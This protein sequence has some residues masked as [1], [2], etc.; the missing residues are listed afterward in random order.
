MTCDT[1]TRLFNKNFFLLWQGQ[2]VSQMGNQAFSIAMMFWIKH[3]TG[4]ATLMGLIMMFSSLPSVLLGPIAGTFADRWS[5]RSIIIW[6]DVFRGVA[7]LLLAGLLFVRGDATDLII[8]CLFIVAVITASMSAFFRPAITAAIPDLVPPDRVASANSMNQS[9]MQASMLAGQSVGGVLFRLL[10]AP[11]LF[12]IDGVSYIVSAISEMFITIPQ[13]KIAETDGAVTALQRFK[14]ETLEG[15]R[16]VWRNR[17]LRD[18]T[19]AA[20]FLNFFLIPIIVLLPF[21]VEDT[22]SSTTDWYGFLL[23]GFGLGALI[24]F[25]GAGLLRPSPRARCWTMISSLVLMS[26]A[27]G[28]LGLVAST[29]SA[30]ILMFLAGTLN[31][32]VNVNIM[33]TMQLMTPS[34][35]R[36]R[37]FGL[38]GTVSGGLAPLAMGLTGVVA[39]L[40]N[41][42]IPLIYVICGGTTA[43]L[44]VLVSFGR[45][46]RS[47]LSY[48]TK[49]EP[50]ENPRP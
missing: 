27:L 4:S 22:L 33:T 7:V 2:F 42:N 13:K 18:L 11:V 3:E 15:L 24:G 36:G 21:Y 50:N 19:L 29:R 16:F 47:F 35:I 10:G 43:V 40:L 6:C 17:G 38:L 20:A 45:E 5:R 48:D 8:V 49:S 44:S 1:P 14:L 41:Q 32:Y 25:A 9:S 28:A 30:L 34:E 23:A 12:L 46:F 26:L 31:G 37:V 39:D